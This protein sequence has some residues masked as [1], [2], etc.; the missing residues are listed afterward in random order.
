[1]KEQ[2][3]GFQACIRLMCKH[4][5]P[6]QEEGFHLLLPHTH[7]HIQ[8]LMDEFSQETDPGLESICSDQSHSF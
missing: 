4:D 3:P 6:V 7:E 8:Q 2:F 5:P 1:L